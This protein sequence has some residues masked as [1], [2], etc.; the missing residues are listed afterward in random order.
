MAIEDLRMDISICNYLCEM[1][2]VKKFTL[3]TVVYND[4]DTNK[5]LIV[6]VT[7]KKNRELSS[8]RLCIVKLCKFVSRNKE[9]G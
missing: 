2:K 7:F 9:R 8:F 4:E 1:T 3:G 6:G 5:Y